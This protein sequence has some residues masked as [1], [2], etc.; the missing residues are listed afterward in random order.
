MLGCLL[1]APY[2]TLA[3]E[4]AT[5]YTKARGH[6]IKGPKTYELYKPLLEIG[7][8]VTGRV[9]AL[10]KADGKGGVEFIPQ[11]E[12]LNLKE[13][14]LED[15]NTHLGYP[16]HPDHEYGILTYASPDQGFFEIRISFEK[17]SDLA[18]WRFSKIL[19]YQIVHLYH[20]MSDW[21]TVNE[22]SKK[23]EK[24]N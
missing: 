23:E 21:I 20:G 12:N 5:Q 22:K 4:L 8:Q 13:M 6:F 15:V 1:L 3:E 11:P 9:L 2:P 18:K 19:K 10:V 7:K 24:E 17:Q 14:T 16:A